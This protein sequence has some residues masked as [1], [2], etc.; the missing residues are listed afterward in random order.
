MDSTGFAT[1]NTANQAG[2]GPSQPQCTDAVPDGDLNSD[3]DGD[4]ADSEDWYIETDPAAE[5]EDELAL[6][7]STDEALY[8]V[9]LLARRR[10]RERQYYRKLGYIVES[11]NGRTRAGCGSASR[12]E[13]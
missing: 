1:T 6:R 3:L 13:N 11:G 8:G 5:L 12:D 2:E 7:K 9:A 4:G 10:A